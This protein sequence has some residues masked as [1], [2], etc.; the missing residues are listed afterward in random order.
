MQIPARDTHI[1]V[2]C[3]IANLGQRASARQVVADKRVPAVVDGESS[4][5]LRAE[6]A[7]RGPEPLPQRVAGEND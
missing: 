4:Q 7:A 3:G 6:Y 5:P 2:P 1:G